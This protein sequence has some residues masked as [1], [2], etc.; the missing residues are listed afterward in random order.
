MIKNYNSIQEFINDFEERI[1]PS[2][3]EIFESWTSCLSTFLNLKREDIKIQYQ[4]QQIIIT[5]PNAYLVKVN[6]IISKNKTIK[7]NLIYHDSDLKSFSISL[8]S[9]D[10]N[11]LISASKKWINSLKKPSCFGKYYCS[12]SCI[13]NGC[14]YQDEEINCDKAKEINEYHHNYSKYETNLQYLYNLLH[15]EVISKGAIQGKVI[16]TINCSSCFYNGKW[17]YSTSPCN[18]CIRNSFLFDKI[19]FNKDIKSI[20]DRYIQKDRMTKIKCKH[21]NDIIQ[22]PRDDW[23]TQCKCKQCAIDYNIMGINFRIIG[24]CLIYNYQKNQWDDLSLI[25]KI[26]WDNY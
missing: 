7:L 25:D 17:D 14:F 19:D 3:L 22:G 15:N 8:P 20:G 2:L 10:L 23:F 24:D 11:E 6:S 4:K 9:T 12:K 18:F 5:Y 21:C 26:N 1:D 13:F 16:K